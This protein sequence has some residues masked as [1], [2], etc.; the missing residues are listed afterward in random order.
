MYNGRGK[1]ASNTGKSNAVVITMSELERI[2]DMCQ[3]VG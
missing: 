3:P 2:K 1:G